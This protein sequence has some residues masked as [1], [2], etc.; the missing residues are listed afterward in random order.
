MACWEQP[1]IDLPL[2][3][4]LRSVVDDTTSTQ[5]ILGR[6]DSPKPQPFLSQFPP[7]RHSPSWI[8]TNRKTHQYARQGAC[9]M[10]LKTTVP[11]GFP[12]F[13]VAQLQ[14]RLAGFWRIIRRRRSIGNHP[15]KQQEVEGESEQQK[16][17]AGALAVRGGDGSDA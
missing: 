10:T 7:R 5:T 11:L 14:L 13:E 1:F 17:R 8:L 3:L 6:M 15:P 16:R 4:P 12:A 9:E 2:I